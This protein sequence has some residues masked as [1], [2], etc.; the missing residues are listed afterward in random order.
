MTYRRILNGTRPG[1]PI[2]LTVL[3]A[4]V[5]R[6]FPATGPRPV[7]TTYTFNLTSAPDRSYGFMGVSYY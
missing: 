5:V 6:D 7:G 1:D 2:N 4:E 3:P